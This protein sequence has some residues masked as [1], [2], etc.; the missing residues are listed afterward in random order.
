MYP[1][2]VCIVG[3]GVV[4]DTE[5]FLKEVEE[6]DAFGT[7]VTDRLFVSDEA[8]PMDAF[9]ELKIELPDAGPVIECLARIVRIE[10]TTQRHFN[11]AVCFL[12]ITGAQRARLNKY[13]D[14]EGGS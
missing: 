6:L 8:P 1:D 7:S 2:K 13:I 11:I 12:D 3:N 14:V 4:F 5:Q 10:Q 9:L